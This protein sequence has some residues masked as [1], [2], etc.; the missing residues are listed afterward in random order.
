M[1][2]LF[3]ADPLESFKTYKD[4]TF[5]MMREAASRG[6]QIWACEPADLVWVR[7]ARV[8][9]RD[10]RAITLTGDEKAWFNVVAEG[11]LALADTPAPQPFA[12]T[13]L[14]NSSSRSASR[15]VAGLASG[16]AT[17]AT[18]VRSIGAKPSLAVSTRWSAWMAISERMLR[19]MPA[20][21]QLSSWAAAVARTQLPSSISKLDSLTAGRNSPGRRR[22]LSMSTWTAAKCWSRSPAVAAASGPLQERFPELDLAEAEVG[23]FGKAVTRSQP[24]QPG[25]RVEIYRKLVADP[26]EVRKQR[27]AEGR[28]KKQRREDAAGD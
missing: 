6:H 26:K 13:V 22:P 12:C 8:V 5:A 21:R 27:A 10:A 2:L 17:S 18:S 25:D 16:A 9:A 7:G 28:L 19:P 1:K 4:T 15:N 23:V 14:Q 3:V 11:E 24:L 20:A